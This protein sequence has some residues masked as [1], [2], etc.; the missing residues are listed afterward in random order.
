[1][2]PDTIN[3][4]LKMDRSLQRAKCVSYCQIR[5]WAQNSQP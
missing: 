3:I 4:S 1:M 5:I 2:E